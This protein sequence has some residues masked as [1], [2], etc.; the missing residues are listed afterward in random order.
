[1]RYGYPDRLV[2]HEKLDATQLALAIANKTTLVNRGEFSLGKGERK[3]GW[4]EGGGG[5]HRPSFIFSQ[6]RHNCGSFI[7]GKTRNNYTMVNY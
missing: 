4:L 6:I 5:T 7:L 3:I 2:S 1:L